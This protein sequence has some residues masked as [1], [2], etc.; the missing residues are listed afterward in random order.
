[1]REASHFFPILIF[2]LL[3][4]HSRQV[5]TIHHRSKKFYLFF[6]EHPLILISFFLK[7]LEYILFLEPR[8]R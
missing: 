5:N 8:M 7:A 3:P 4:I 6:A 2:T 1:M